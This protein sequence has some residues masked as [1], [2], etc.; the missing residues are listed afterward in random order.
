[1]RCHTWPG[2]LCA[3]SL[4]YICEEISFHARSSRLFAVTDVIRLDRA[5]SLLQRQYGSSLVHVHLHVDHQSNKYEKRKANGSHFICHLP[6]TER[7]LPDRSGCYAISMALHAIPRNAISWPCNT[8]SGARLAIGAVPVN[9]RRWTILN[10]V[11]VET[12]E[13]CERYVLWLDGF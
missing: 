10:D 13:R 4:A 6:V 3:L 1:V 7:T 12:G 9:V 2:Q 8:A 5:G 11:C